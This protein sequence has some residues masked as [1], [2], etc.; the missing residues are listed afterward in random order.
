MGNGCKAEVCI[1]RE[2]LAE[3]GMIFNK[4]ISFPVLLC[5][6]PV[7]TDDQSNCWYCP[8]MEKDT[9]KK[10]L[11]CILDN[12]TLD[13]MLNAF[14]SFPF[15]YCGRN[16]NRIYELEAKTTFPRYWEISSRTAADSYKF[17]SHREDLRYYDE[18][19]A[20]FRRCALLFLIAT[21][22]YLR[23]HSDDDIMNRIFWLFCKNR[24]CAQEKMGMLR[25]VKDQAYCQSAETSGNFFR[26]VSDEIGLEIHN[27][28]LFLTKCLSSSEDKYMI[29]GLEKN[30]VSY[31][32]GIN[33]E[34]KSD[35]QVSA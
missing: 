3:H 15:A 20:P 23:G 11:I 5:K 2:C 19:D 16:Q 32:I 6:M 29:E 35:Y 26:H 18:A 24:R 7:W 33:G 22:I 17:C 21:E 1:A 9:L 31:L 12:D 34:E 10:I 14:D 25:D 30:L 27:I 4:N 28:F 8:F 13:K